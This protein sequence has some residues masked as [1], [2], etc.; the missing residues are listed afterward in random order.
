MSDAIKV[1]S[2]VHLYR[3]VE[4]G[5][6][7][8][9]GYE[10]WEYGDQP[11]VKYSESPGTVDDVVAAMQSS[12]IDKAVMV[13]L[14]SSHLTRETAIAS[15][16][17]DLGAG[18]REKAL[19][20][21]DAEV[22][23]KLKTFNQWGCDVAREHPEIAAFIAADAIGLPGKA[24]AD[25]IR[26]MV[27]NHGAHGVKLHGAFQN[28]YMYDERLWPTYELCQEL[29]IPI[30]G[31]AGPD[32]DGSG[33]AEPRSFGRMLGEFP[34]LTMVLAHMG[35]ARWQQTLEIAQAHPNAYFDCCEIIEWTN[36]THGPS[37]Q[38]LARLIK[39][40]GPERVMMGSDFPWYDLDHTIERVM[41]LPLLSM[42]EKEGIL[43]ANAVRILGLDP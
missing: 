15:L 3:S 30:I 6:E 28:F 43:G 19:Q 24:G 39:D 4:E 5:L 14:F 11:I 22:L 35:G 7:E 16:P 17:A 25:H 12:G 41:E 13:N 18:A 1:D 21:I 32:R 8:K 26:D 40:V 34:Q 20:Q 27:E 36:S 37:E 38:Q 29:N 9:D 23:T 31:H 33:M 10:V 2:H 42:E